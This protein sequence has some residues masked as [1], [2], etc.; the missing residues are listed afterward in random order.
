[1]NYLLNIFIVELEFE[2]VKS[3]LQQVYVSEAVNVQ[4]DLCYAS[5]CHARSLEE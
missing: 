3:L 1:M 2:I 5:K 4:H